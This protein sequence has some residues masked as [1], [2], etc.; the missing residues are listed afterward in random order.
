MKQALTRY[1]IAAFVAAGAVLLQA[2][3]GLA[4]H[5]R[6]FTGYYGTNPCTQDE[7]GYPVFAIASGL[8]ASGNQL[9]NAGSR[10][11]SP[12]A[13]TYCG[14]SAVTQQYV[15]VS[16]L[17]PDGTSVTRGQSGNVAFTSTSNVTYNNFVHGC[18]FTA[19]A[20]GTTY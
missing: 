6:L 18:S 14:D 1:G 13:E 5:Q 20:K 15:R 3:P 19:V 12:V 8:D 17:K 10:G 4:A 11:A 2:V 7:Q 9:C 16:G